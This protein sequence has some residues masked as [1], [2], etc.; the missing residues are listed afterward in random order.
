MT[1]LQFIYI[2]F[3][4]ILIIAIAIISD[5]LSFFSTS[6]NDESS[7]EEYDETPNIGDFEYI[8][9]VNLVPTASL[10]KTKTFGTVVNKKSC[11]EKCTYDHSCH[12]YTH[13]NQ[14]KTCNLL[15]TQNLGY[16]NNSKGVSTTVGGIK[17]RV[18]L[19]PTDKYFRVENNR[20]NSKNKLATFNNLGGLQQCR[21][22]C[23][24]DAQCKA[25]DYDFKNQICNTVG[26]VNSTEY[27]E[28]T[29]SYIILK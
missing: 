20:I 28:N 8:G 16:E 14:Q 13:D 9:S 1:K 15:N 17:K 22:K 21:M 24:I 2:A 10:E 27:D 3:T 11:E 7:L 4:L 12:G 6:V 29:D 25:F 23:I 18:V 5:K 26:Q 19:E